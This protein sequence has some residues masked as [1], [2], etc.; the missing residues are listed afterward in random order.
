MPEDLTKG[1]KLNV[2][3]LFSHSNEKDSSAL[4]VAALAVLCWGFSA[5]ASAQEEFFCDPEDPTCEQ[6]AEAPAQ[7]DTS[8]QMFCD[9]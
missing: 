4:G 5:E 3:R 6:P 8:G 7:E 1:Y 2:F 9:P